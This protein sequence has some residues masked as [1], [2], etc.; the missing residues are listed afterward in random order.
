[1]RAHDRAAMNSAK[2]DR[3]AAIANRREALRMDVETYCELRDLRNN[4]IE[5]DAPADL[6]DGAMTFGQA[7]KHIR[8]KWS[9]EEWAAGREFAR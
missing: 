6:P 8:Q 9:A 5:D 2:A 4:A 1:M 7:M 3:A